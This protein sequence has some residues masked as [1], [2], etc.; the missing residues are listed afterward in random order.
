MYSSERFDM[1]LAKALWYS[2]IKNIYIFR[3]LTYNG[4]NLRRRPKTKET[5][6][7]KRNSYSSTKVSKLLLGPHRP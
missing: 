3:Q 6:G 4:R 1:V 5:T 7:L 2:I